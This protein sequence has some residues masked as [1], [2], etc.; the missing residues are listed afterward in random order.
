MDIG[1]W[2]IVRG[3]RENMIL[4]IH[5]Q[6]AALFIFPPPSL[7]L[8]LLSV[9]SCKWASFWKFVWPPH[10]ETDH[11]CLAETRLQT[12]QLS[13]V[14]CEHKYF[15]RLLLYIVQ[16]RKHHMSMQRPVNHSGPSNDETKPSETFQDISQWHLPFTINHTKG[17]RGQCAF[18]KYQPFVFDKCPWL[19]QSRTIVLYVYPP[20]LTFVH[21]N[22][23][24]PT[25]FS[26]VT[27][28]ALHRVVWKCPG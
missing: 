11:R 19:F 25:A 15:T 18:C 27:G 23:I 17:R 24:S 4:L 12:L 26:A 7:T 3:C 8:I 16:H 9:L 10:L 21:K 14:Q 5:L 22:S 1:W 6:N 28:R 2:M 13:D 20:N